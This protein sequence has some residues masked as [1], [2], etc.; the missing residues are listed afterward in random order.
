MSFET[1]V[2]IA[3]LSSIAFVCV[4]AFWWLPRQIREDYRQGLLAM[5][6]TV[7]MRERDESGSAAVR[8]RYAER[9]A[10]SLRLPRT[11]IRDIE[12]AALLQEIGKV[13]IPYRIL[14]K[15]A[16]LTYEEAEVLKL[17]P[18]I[19]Q[20]IVQHVPS[21]SRVAPIIRYHHEN[22]DGTG[23]PDGLRGEEIPLAARV[24]HIV[25]DFVETLRRE[26]H[27]DPLA[28]QKA[29]EQMEQGRGTLYDPILLQMFHEL[30][31]SEAGEQ[32]S[33]TDGAVTRTLS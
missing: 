26:G 7:E 18:V 23:Y 25:G 10:R 24:L 8:A 31:L 29:L 15:G 16:P 4:Y 11:A 20:H 13:A 3:T 30:V 6:R 1:I 5:A 12:L 33:R 17:H 27:Q 32:V 19:G 21:L 9:L 22:W 14:N 2:Y 28:K